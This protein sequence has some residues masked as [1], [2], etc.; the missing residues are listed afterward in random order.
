MQRQVQ[1]PYVHDGVE[2]LT[3]LV[4]ARQD[5]LHAIKHAETKACP[6]AESLTYLWLRTTIGSPALMTGRYELSPFLDQNSSLCLSNLI[7]RLFLLSFQNAPS[8]S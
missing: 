8:C 5:V 1:F 7:R 3:V 4:A 2:L 6:P